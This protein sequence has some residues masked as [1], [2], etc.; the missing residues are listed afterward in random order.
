ME[1]ARQILK[2]RHLSIFHLLDVEE[3]SSVVVKGLCYKPAGRG[4]ETR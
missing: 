1:L 3:R 4:F 2:G